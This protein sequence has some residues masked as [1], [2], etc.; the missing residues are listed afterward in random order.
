M[1][2]AFLCEFTTI[3]STFAQLAIIYLIIGIV[4]GIAMESL[5]ALTACI[6]A[7]TPFLLIFTL[8]G[9]DATNGWERFRACLP[10]SRGA[11]VA[12]RYAIVLVATL[13]MI[14]LSCILALALGALAPTLPLSASTAESLAEQ[15]DLSLLLISGLAGSGIVLLVSALVL[16]FLI[17]FGMNKAMRIVPVVV[18]LAILLAIASFSQLAELGAVAQLLHDTVENPASQPLVIAGTVVAVLAIYVISFL[19]AVR[20]YRTKEL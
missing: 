10:V 14:A 12:S 15:A 3:R 20:L 19:A 5:V 1:K 13:A 7:M 2:A 6:G 17:R 4:L 8:A 18:M 11:I 16:P 9:Y